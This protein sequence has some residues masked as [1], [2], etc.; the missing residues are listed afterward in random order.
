MIYSFNTYL[1][2]FG[3]YYTLRREDGTLS[4][5]SFL[6]KEAAESFAENAPESSTKWDNLDAFGRIANAKNPAALQKIVN[7][8]KYQQQIKENQQVIFEFGDAI[9]ALSEAGVDKVTLGTLVKSFTNSGRPEA[10]IFRRGP[11]LAGYSENFGKTGFVPEHNPPAGYIALT[12]FENATKGQWDQELKD[13][14]AEKFN[15][16]ALDKADDPG[17]GAGATSLKSG[18]AKHFDIRVDNPLVRYVVSGGNILNLKNLNGKYIAEELGIDKRFV[19]EDADF[20]DQINKSFAA[21][22]GI[23]ISEKRKKPELHAYDFDDTLFN[24]NSQVI[25][26]KADGTKEKLNSEDFPGHELGKGESYDFAEFD[27]VIEPKALE[28]LKE[29]EQSLKNGNDVV[30]LTARTMNAKGPVLKLLQEKFGDKAKNIKFKGVGHSSAQAKVNYL[31]NAINK[32]GYDNVYFTDDAIKNVEAV[33]AALDKIKDVNNRVKLAEAAGISATDLFSE[34]VAKAKKTK[35]V[36]KKRT[37][38]WSLIPPGAEDFEGL[39]NTI[40][41]ESNDLLNRVKDYIYK[42]YNDGVNQHNGIKVGLLQNFKKLGFSK[43]FLRKKT[44]VIVDGNNLTNSQVARLAIALSQGSD[45]LNLKPRH[46]QR[47]NDY[48]NSN[49]EVQDLISKIPSV[50]ENA[51]RAINHEGV[52]FQGETIDPKGSLETDLLDFANKTVREFTMKTFNERSKEFFSDS[53]MKTLEGLYG[54][55]FTVALKNML[56]RMKSG[57]NRPQINDPYLN[58]VLDWINGSQAVIMFLNIRS[59]GLQLLSIGNFFKPS[60]LFAGNYKVFG[61][62]KNYAKTIGMLWNSDYLKDRRRGVKIDVAS[63]EI[64]DEAFNGGTFKEFLAKVSSVGF[65]PTKTAD[66]LAVAIG[67]AM[68]YQAK[69]NEGMSHE[70]AMKAF[71]VEAEKAQQ[72]SRPDRISSQQASAVGRLLLAFA[73]TPIQ[74]ARQIKRGVGTLSR[75]DSST[76]D[77]ADAAAKI[78]Y[79]GA[80]QSILFTSLQQMLNVYGLFDD[81]EETKDEQNRL[82][83]GINSIIDSLLRGTGLIGNAAAAIKN[84]LGPDFA[85]L[86]QEGE[87]EFNM[88]PTKLWGVSPPLSAK[89]NKLDLSKKDL[90]GRYSPTFPGY[91]AAANTISAATN[92]PTDWLYKKLEVAKEIN[93]KELSFY[94]ALMRSAGYTKK[95]LGVDA[96]PIDPFTG[97]DGDFKSFFGR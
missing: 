50:Y 87:L 49:K 54:K 83:W 6:T 10:N 18:T 60:D 90:Q 88:D 31:V 95:Q 75:K 35:Y 78:L 27:Q 84:G 34:A 59:A 94:E 57:K 8:A 22:N 86:V 11:R 4:K 69:R 64:L 67:G 91:F 66:S 85:K 38:K 81:E 68:F 76:G 48:V 25:V 63:E 39:L 16:Y 74:Y 7:D 26:N 23:V 45:K 36:D 47:I 71:E 79:Y 56:G 20:V 17:Q 61:N 19:P 65:W 77:K 12:L 80:L 3:K 24:T 70:D 58:Q 51:N 44:G 15:Y 55:N 5:D 9:Q 97:G 14:I 89:I 21:K 53:N 93:D 37:K 43:K 30:I 82:N 33:K 42:P 52:P 46:V 62:D 28:A 32:H 40:A 41:G 13:A 29:L 96:K 1:N 2:S 72:S 92:L 73:N